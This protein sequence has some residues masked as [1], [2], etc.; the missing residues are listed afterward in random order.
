[1]KKLLIILMVGSLF[2]GCAAKPIYLMP[3]DGS[4]SDGTVTLSG[5]YGALSA[6]KDSFCDLYHTPLNLVISSFIR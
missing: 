6:F 4:K 1:M 3:S 5:E 2:I